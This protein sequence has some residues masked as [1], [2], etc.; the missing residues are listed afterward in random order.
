MAE[1]YRL[2][3]KAEAALLGRL[4]TIAGAQGE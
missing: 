1:G 4:A 3:P 2:T